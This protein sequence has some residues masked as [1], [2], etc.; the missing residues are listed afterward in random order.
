MS[1]AGAR[2]LC[3]ARAEHPILV[4]EE[5]LQSRFFT[6]R[7]HGGGDDRCKERDGITY[8][9]LR[10]KSQLGSSVSSFF[11]RGCRRSGAP[12]GCDRFS[13]FD[14]RSG[15]AAEKPKEGAA[16]GGSF[17][18]V[19]DLKGA[20]IPDKPLVLLGR[21][22]ELFYFCERIASGRG[23]VKK[24]HPYLDFAGKPRRDRDSDGRGIA[25][26]ARNELLRAY[27]DFS[28][29]LG[30]DVARVQNAVVHIERL[31]IALNRRRIGF[32][33]EPVRAVVDTDLIPCGGGHNSWH[34]PRRLI[35]DAG[36][37]A[38]ARGDVTRPI[39]PLPRYAGV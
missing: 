38:T 2:R 9:G 20:G 8:A 10:R 23:P 30:P 4:G 34:V 25:P 29:V 5:R 39:A 36:E 14:M 3:A 37:K 13:H 27:T 11:V 33:I 16:V 22:I 17:A 28:V 31:T 32:G 35:V 19:A 12:L 6:V 7:S 26:I 21:G 15:R 1:R 18:H 24:T